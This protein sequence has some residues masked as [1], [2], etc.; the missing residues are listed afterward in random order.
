MSHDILLNAAIDGRIYQYKFIFWALKK[1]IEFG[2][3]LE[4][5]TVWLWRKKRELKYKK[6]ENFQEYLRLWLK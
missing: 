2:T 6:K 4:I 5:K 1:C 3:I